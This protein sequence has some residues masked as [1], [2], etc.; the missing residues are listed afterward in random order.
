M[1]SVGHYRLGRVLGRGAFGEVREGFDTIAKRK[2][3]VKIIR[4]KDVSSI[5]DAERVSREFF[6]L[7]S[8]EHKHVTRLYEV[9]A[10]DNYMY[11]FMVRGCVRL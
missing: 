3:A 6:I 1:P 2:V 9:T 4:N 5:A 10:D 7:T 11:I 8:L